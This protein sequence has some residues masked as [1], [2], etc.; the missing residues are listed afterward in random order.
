M[1]TTPLTTKHDRINPR[2]RT[3]ALIGPYGAVCG[4]AEFNRFFS[5]ALRAKDI[6]VTHLANRFSPRYP[7]HTLYDDTPNIT[8]VFGTGHSPKEEQSF[9]TA[10]VVKTV[11]DSGAKICYLNYQDYL[12]PDKAGLYRALAQLASRGV[13]LHLIIHDTCLPQDMP[14][15]AFRGIVCPSQQVR[16]NRFPTAARTTVIPMGVPQFEPHDRNKLREELL[17]GVPENH[18]ITTFGLGRSNNE[19]VLAAADAASASLKRTETN[20]IA[21]Q[22]IFANMDDYAHAVEKWADKD[23]VFLQ[24]GYQEDFRLA[25]Y[26]QAS[27]AVVINY[28]DIT[29][30]ATSSALR[31]AVGAGCVVLAKD[32]NWM[33]DVTDR[34]LF[35]PFVSSTGL[36]SLV[37]QLESLFGS[38]NSLAAAKSMAVRN[39]AAYARENSWARVVEQ[40][41]EMWRRTV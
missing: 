28:P 38:E 9:D 23:N 21:V 5:E 8:R 20:P 35:L 31:F 15:G 14:Y 19:E 17:L 10:A 26:L 27:D 34:N 6:Q 12:Y 11:L 37:S 18:I 22:M 2:F 36:K 4:V 13:A 7:D 32:N 24:G 39:G 25:Y 33:A 30:Y 29:H 40:H 16:S 1:N 41:I 3:V